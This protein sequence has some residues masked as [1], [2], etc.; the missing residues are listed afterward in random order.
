M[1]ELNKNMHGPLLCHK[2]QVLFVISPLFCDSSL[3]RLFLP[4]TQVNYHSF[5]KAANS[6]LNPA[7]LQEA[8]FFF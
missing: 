7:A 1:S 2:E 5:L 4:F 6:G 3:L 8:F